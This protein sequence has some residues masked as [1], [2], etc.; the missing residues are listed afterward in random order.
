MRCRVCYKKL[1]KKVDCL[2]VV[3]KIWKEEGSYLLVKV[4]IRMLSDFYSLVRLGCL[5]LN[6]NID[7]IE[8]KLF[9]ILLVN[10]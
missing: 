9:D 7:E 10:V 8:D 5:I 2:I 4:F 3:L 6:K 1:E